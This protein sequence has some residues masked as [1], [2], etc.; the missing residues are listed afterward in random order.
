VVGYILA[1]IVDA[2]IQHQDGSAHPDPL[3]AT[4]HYLKAS[5]AGA[6]EARVRRLRVG[7]GYANLLADFVQEVRAPPIPRVTAQ[8]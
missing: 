6:F 7:R 4:A 5:R 2:C 8:H 3:H 1:L